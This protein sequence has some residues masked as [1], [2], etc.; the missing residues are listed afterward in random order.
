M[1]FLLLSS[2]AHAGV[3]YITPHIDGISFCHSA[4]KDLSVK[5][6]EE[7]ALFCY[8]KGE[9]SSDTI[10]NELNKIDSG[11]IRNGN[12]ELGYTLTIPLFRYYQQDKSGKWFVNQSFLKHDIDVINHIDRPV[13]IYL[14]L[15]H[16]ADSNEKL[17]RELAKDS[18][19]IMWNA[20]GPMPIS[21]YFGNPVIPWT[22]SDY[23][24]PITQ[25]R[26]NVFRDALL[27]IKTVIRNHPGRVIG[28]SILGEV[29]QMNKNI[30]AGPSYSVD[31]NDTSDYS[32]S[33]VDGFRHWLKEKFAN[34][35]QMNE[36]F[37]SSY[38]SFDDVSPPTRNIRKDILKSFFEHNDNF[39]SGSMDIY[40]WMTDSR[41]CKAAINVYLDG[42]NIGRATYGLNRTD[43][44]EAI[45]IRN[46]NVGFRYSLN[47][48]K[49]K[50]GSHK[51][52]LTESCN[53]KETLLDTRA[54]SYVDRKQ[55]P[56]ALISVME[57]S[58]PKKD[59]A[60]TISVDGPKANQ[61]VFYNP[62]VELWQLYR[63]YEVK[64]Y[65]QHFAQIAAQ[66][67][68]ADLIFS[69]QI[70]TEL[71]GAWNKEITAEEDSKKENNFYNQGTTLYGG[72]AFGDA[73]FT[74]A[75]RDGWRTYSISEMNP[76]S[77]IGVD[78]YV[79]M[80]NR[81]N[82]AGAKFVSP[83]FISV[84]SDSRPLR[85]LNMF[86][87]R[88]GNTSAHSDQFYEAIKRVMQ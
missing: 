18:R 26:E 3:T 78:G 33:S 68:P 36:L 59:A 23:S 69:H 11:K 76:M 71:N 82:K 13:N 1:L 20:Q 47:F 10:N 45:G 39:A 85:G 83:Y 8:K 80:L 42:K 75:K 58:F 73:F 7:A 35:N 5:N 4:I 14:S 6:N 38:T 40:G 52:W 32:P 37:G 15:N 50:Y 43:V 30:M 24:A 9:D 70:S 62:L 72:A 65:L 27:Q 21:D 54:F 66:Y 88:P 41:S 57:P 55:S 49:I 81:H 28:V 17:S 67:I 19:N 64:Q 46:P 86:E 12:F 25:Y 34:I 22:I 16:F 48:K 63:Q 79:N 84:I 2:S 51:V 61:D 29:H 87:M 60:V 56:T 31:M 44:A 74:N 53:G 77:D